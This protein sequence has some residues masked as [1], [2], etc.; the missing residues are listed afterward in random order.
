MYLR[1]NITRQ[2][3]INLEKVSHFCSHYWLKVLKYWSI[4]HQPCRLGGKGELDNWDLVFIA[5]LFHFNYQVGLNT[6]YGLTSEIGTT[7]FYNIL[8]ITSN[9]HHLVKSFF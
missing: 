5:T 7:K 2:I 4:E 6:N 1:S 8:K 3:C 9:T